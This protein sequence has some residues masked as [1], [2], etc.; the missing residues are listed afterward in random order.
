MLA[1]ILN[2]HL[3]FRADCGELFLERRHVRIASVEEIDLEALY[4]LLRETRH[5]ALLVAVH[6][7]ERQPMPEA[8]APL[9]RIFDEMVHIDGWTRLPDVESK[10][11]LIAV[12]VK[13]YI[14]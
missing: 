13:N 11:K 1:M 12:P 3:V 4:A 9:L 10:A 8:D 5:H 14:F 7:M 6:L 2:L